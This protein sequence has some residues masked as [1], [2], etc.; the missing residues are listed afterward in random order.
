MKYFSTILILLF[1]ATTLLYS[2]RID[3]NA[4]PKA[5]TTKSI[6]GEPAQNAS[7]VWHYT[8]LSGCAGG[9]G[10]AGMCETCGNPLVHNTV[11][12]GGSTPTPTGP[13]ANAPFVVPPAT[14]SA[15]NA[16]GVWHYTCSKGCAGGAG[17]AGSC[18]NC[19]N[20]LAHNQAYHQ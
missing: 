7:G 14:T 2:C 17:A 6:T 5:K 18:V 3:P 13:N 19:G 9:A 4:A 11:Y 20:T 16:N 8:C 10:A 1:I 15:T 12:H